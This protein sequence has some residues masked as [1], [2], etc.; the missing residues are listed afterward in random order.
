MV[1]IPLSYNFILFFQQ[2]KFFSQ[3]FALQFRI[4]IVT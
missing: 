4:F 3:F 2:I 1:K